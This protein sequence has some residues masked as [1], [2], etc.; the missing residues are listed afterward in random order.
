MFCFCF[1]NT[2]FLASALSH[3]VIPSV[4]EGDVCGPSRKILLSA[5]QIRNDTSEGQREEGLLF[6]DASTF[7][8]PA[9]PLSKCV[10]WFHSGFQVSIGV[11]II[12]GFW[13]P[14]PRC[15]LREKRDA[16]CGN[17]AL[18]P[19]SP[20][21]V[22]PFLITTRLPRSAVPTHIHEIRCNG[23]EARAKHMRRRD[24]CAGEGGAAAADE[25]RSGG[26]HGG[27]RL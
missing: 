19:S 8:F 24:V 10:V 22:R 11:V 7:A 15:I 3:L 16:V 13:V 20:S 18:S 9:P 21:S 14:S 5:V 4:Y 2:V 27:R 6:A 1:S 25:E 23:G 12:W 17:V 26:D